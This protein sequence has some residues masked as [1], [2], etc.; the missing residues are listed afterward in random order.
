MPSDSTE[1]RPAM[2]ARLGLPAA[3]PDPSGAPA[4]DGMAPGRM[5]APASAFEAAE[6]LAE[7]AAQGLAVAPVGGGTALALGN[8]PDRLDLA[9]ST[10]RL[11]GVLEYEPTDLVLS[12]GAGARL[13][14]VQAVLAE[15][16]QELPIDAARPDGATIGGLVA[17]GLAGPRRL[18]AG[19]LRD[20]L[21]GISVAHPSGTV[22]KAGGMVVKNVTGFDLP[23]LY[24]G[25]LGTLGLI[26]SANF[27]VLP[28]PRHDASVVGAFAGLDD[29]LGAAARIRG[30][31]VQPVA[32]EVA[33]AEPGWIVAVRLQGR[34]ATVG[35]LVERVA[36]T[37][38]TGGGLD[39]RVDEG[40]DSGA[41]WQAYVDAQVVES[42][43]G[44]VLVRVAVR[45]RGVDDLAREVVGI[46]AERGLELRLLAVSTGL[47]SV[48]A[49]L[50]FPEGSGGAGALLDLR[51]SLL[52]VAD[53]ATI[54]AAPPAWKA[55]LDVWGELPETIGVMR[56]LKAQ[57]DPER[58]LNRGRFAGNI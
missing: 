33:R 20:L 50:G 10:A 23:R 3:S 47:G 26:V 43:R 58:V 39:A 14:D 16:G 31:T 29:A 8:V 36:A 44:E 4:I 6:A 55:G 27:K 51:R 1:A 25:S 18:G 37:I 15:H 28:R 22:T 5:L 40:A 34:P 45:P 11:G 24:H 38:G 17:T 57:F 53:Q 32:L 21:I 12:V 52:G 19:T 35:A 46:A 54:L 13:A 42:G 41:W 7:A 48:V 9:L 2:A 56:T 49:R 30:S